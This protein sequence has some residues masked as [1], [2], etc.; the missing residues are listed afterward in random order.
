[1]TMMDKG[2]T[3]DAELVLVTPELAQQWLDS[4]GRNRNLRPGLAELLARD[5]TAGRWVFTGDTI[6]FSN[7]VMIDGQHRCKAIVLS[8]VSLPMLV[9]RGLAANAQAN[10]DMGARRGAGDALAI[11]GYDDSHILAAAARLALRIQANRPRSR[12][13]VSHAEILEFVTHH[14][15]LA[16]AVKLARSHHGVAINPSVLAYCCWRLAQVDEHA[17]HEF[18]YSLDANVFQ[19]R[20]DPRNTLARRL[21]A[22]VVRRE[23]VPAPTMVAWVFRVWNAWRTGR[24][25]TVLRAVAY[26]KNAT[27]APGQPASAPIA[28]PEPR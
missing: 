10:T 11:S 28:I 12:S 19:S 1:M 3:P 6:K 16:D 15:E 22:A 18:L 20:T 26:D 14:P 17:L 8:G 25:V 5:M 2:A 27:P 21:N 9:V 24:A 23:H 4:M 7:G 13:Q